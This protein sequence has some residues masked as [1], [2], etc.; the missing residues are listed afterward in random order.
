MRQLVEKLKSLECEISSDKGE[1]ALFGLFLRED[2]QDRWDLLVS[3]PWLDAA[4]K[5]SLEF[6]VN[7]LRLSL[8]SEELLSLSRVVLLDADNPVLKAVNRAVKVH[9]GRVEVKNDKFFGL[10][11]EHAYIITSKRQV[12]EITSYRDLSSEELDRR[13]KTSES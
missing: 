1:F 7:Q 5:E 6:I 4:K 9:H 13:E 3:A 8:E 2:A 10:Q 12:D 11:I